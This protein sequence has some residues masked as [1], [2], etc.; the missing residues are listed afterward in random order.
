MAAKDGGLVFE[1]T[2]EF[3]NPEEHFLPP[4]WE[5][6]TMD[7]GRIYY[8]NHLT[9]STQW[10]H[11]TSGKRYKV[12]GELP[13]GWQQLYDSKG[14]VFFFDSVNRVTTYAD[15]RI[16]LNF[17]KS[18]KNSKKLDSHSTAMHVLNGE[19]LSG[20]VAIV[21]GANSGI[22]F[23]TAKALALHGAHVI[24]ACR[25]MNKANRAA[26]MIRQTPEAY[27]E[28][29]LLDLA[30]F[31]SI[32]NFAEEFR[33]RKLPLHIL[34]C[35]AAVFGLSWSKTEDGIESTFGVNH[36]GHFYLVKLI[37]DILCSSSPARV[38][39]LSSE[40]HRFPD[41][42]Y[43]TKL[44][45]SELPLSKDKYWSI[46]AYNQSKLC[47]LLFS[48]E[49]NRRLKPKG[50]TCNAVHPGNLIYTSLS[51]TSWFY[52][53]FFVMARPF[54]KTPRFISVYS[55]EYATLG[56]GKNYLTNEEKDK[57][58]IIWKL[59][60]QQG[61]DEKYKNFSHNEI[62]EMVL[63]KNLDPRLQELWDKR[64]SLLVDDFKEKCNVTDE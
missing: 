13:Q 34:I 9:K 33:G 57:A 64:E 28:A 43:S 51:H 19:D 7:D 17:T 8:A 4:G 20:K 53:I 29:M 49:L 62:D 45:L 11:P 50:V 35:N 60:K 63:A 55:I 37:E 16:A 61:E 27:V 40:S 47:N 58:N 22:G 41:L 46:V 44:P 14:S 23:E 54:A 15:P 59:V 24:L 12:C 39:V 31:T 38:V 26:A 1:E 30:S 6:R 52:W 56:V 32:K 2:S 48:M 18:K 25:N 3:K 5:I 10:E 21:T 36:L 42:T